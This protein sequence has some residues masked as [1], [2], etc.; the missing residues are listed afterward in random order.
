MSSRVP[1]HDRGGATDVGLATLFLETNRCRSPGYILTYVPDSLP[2]RYLLV[3][4]AYVGMYVK[5]V[6]YH[7]FWP[8]FQ[9]ALDPPFW[10]GPSE[11]YLLIGVDGCIGGN[12]GSPAPAKPPNRS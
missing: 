5:V 1:A 6:T 10:E 3:L 12:I 7:T 8:P 9:G 2:P 11:S 4:R